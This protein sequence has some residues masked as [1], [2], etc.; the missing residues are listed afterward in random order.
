MTTQLV[1]LLALIVWLEI[2]GRIV[3]GKNEPIMISLF[4]SEP[5]TDFD[6]VLYPAVFGDAHDD[7]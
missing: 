6:R 3:A 4:G 2:M 1:K 5:M 7:D